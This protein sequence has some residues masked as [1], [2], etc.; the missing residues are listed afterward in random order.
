M[1]ANDPSARGVQ[2]I[3]LAEDDVDMR[4]F[5]VKALAKRALGRATARESNIKRNQYNSLLLA[6]YGSTDVV[7]DLAAAEERPANYYWESTVLSLAR[8]WGREGA[9]PRGDT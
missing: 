3:L 6:H 7:F 9:Y 8:A 5:L 1:V 2:R 4:R